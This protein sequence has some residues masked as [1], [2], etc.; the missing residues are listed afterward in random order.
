MALIKKH[1]FKTMTADAMN[2][3]LTELRKELVKLNAQVSRGTPPENPGKIRTIK[4]NI[5]RLITFTEQKKRGGV[6]KANE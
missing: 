1:E 3:R 5:A 4:R 2:S 6:V